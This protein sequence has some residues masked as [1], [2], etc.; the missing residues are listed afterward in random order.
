MI[1]KEVAKIFKEMAD[2]LDIMGEKIPQRI[3]PTKKRLII[4][5]SCKLISPIYIENRV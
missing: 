5:I 4:W 1:N 2:L 3:L